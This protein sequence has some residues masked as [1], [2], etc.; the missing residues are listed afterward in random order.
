MDEFQTQKIREFLNNKPM[1]DA[2]YKIL[3]DSFLNQP[4]KDIYMLGASR[5]AVDFLKQGW[6][7]LKSSSAIK[8]Q[9]TSKGNVGL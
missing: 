1:S 8:E 6:D 2:V 7:R 3:F 5:L 9:S 4:S